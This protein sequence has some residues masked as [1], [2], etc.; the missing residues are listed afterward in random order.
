MCT[1]GSMC[2]RVSMCVSV[3]AC[4]CTQADGNKGTAHAWGLPGP[5]RW[6]V[7]ETWAVQEHRG[8]CAVSTG[9]CAGG[10][11]WGV[12][13]GARGGG[14]A[15]SIVGVPCREHRGALWGA[16]RPEGA[17]RAVGA[18]AHPCLKLQGTVRLLCR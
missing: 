16:P 1:Y 4:V 7:R 2:T 15:E 8:G 14:C 3:C 12:V 13:W 17:E 9:S 6:S 10:M 11:R 5:L 18:S